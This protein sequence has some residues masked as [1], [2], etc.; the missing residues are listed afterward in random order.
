MGLPR[1]DWPW[2]RHR[3]TSAIAADDPEF[4]T[5]GGTAATLTAA[6]RELFAYFLDVY[7]E[8]R[9]NLGDDLVSVLVGTE[10]DG[11]AMSPGEVLS[12]CYSLLLG[13]SVTTP[14]PPTYVLAEHLD[15]GTL[16]RWASSPDAT[17][18]AVEEALR[19]SS[20]ATHFLRYAVADTEVG[21]T[22]IGAGQ[23]VV[24]WLGAANRDPGV[25]PDADR[26]D[27]H[28]TP[29]RHLAFGIGPHYCV[30]HNIARLTLRTVFDELLSRFRDL[31]LV[32]APERLRSTVVSGYKHLPVTARAVR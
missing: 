30:G 7:G 2:L 3:L 23:A 15:D 27:P 18:S 14:H 24:C 19:L 11:R 12:N 1:A 31:R 28:R 29:N 21:G 22:R 4:R 8:R 13:A 32:G 5:A 9:R 26:F 17:P 25:F 16:D 6:H 10:V 20:P